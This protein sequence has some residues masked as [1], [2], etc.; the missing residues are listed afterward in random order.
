[1]ATNPMKARGVTTSLTPPKPAAGTRPAR[2]TTTKAAALDSAWDDGRQFT[3]RI[4]V[5]MTPDQYEALRRAGFDARIG[6][7]AIVRG[8]IDRYLDDP[9]LAAEINQVS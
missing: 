3:A 1:M 6:M 8:L 2:K 9:A 7:S 4:T 5:D